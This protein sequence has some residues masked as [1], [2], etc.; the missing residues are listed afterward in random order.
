VE[1]FIN[2]RQPLV[3]SEQSFIY[4]KEDLITLRPGREHA[5]LD[6]AV[7]RLLRISRCRTIQVCHVY[8]WVFRMQL[9]LGQDFFRSK[10]GRN[11]QGQDLQLMTRVIGN[12]AK[13]Q[14]QRKLLHTP[15]YRAFCCCTH[16]VD[17]SG[18]FGHPDISP[19]PSDY[20]CEL[21][22]IKCNL[23]RCSAHFHALFLGMLVAFHK[24]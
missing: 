12:Q 13:D 23:H 16:C 15:S 4:C 10:V 14:W 19:I 22:A 5:W 24:S 20:W 1:N 6:C 18:T 17:D 9:T 21:T 2:N 8:V 7:E 3:P 11:P